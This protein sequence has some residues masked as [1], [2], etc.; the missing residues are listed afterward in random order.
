MARG[1]L[2]V[3]VVSPAAMVFEGDASSLVAPSWDGRVGILPGHA[4]FLALLGAG[5][6]AVDLP[7]GG[8]KSFQVAGGVIKVLENRVTILT[9]YA[10]SEP[11]AVIPPEAI[12]HEEDVAMGAGDSLA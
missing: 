7:G 8:S 10:G 3:R 12:V 2:D 4:P 5:E 11:P 1:A 9:E 6:L